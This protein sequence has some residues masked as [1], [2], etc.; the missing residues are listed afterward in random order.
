MLLSPHYLKSVRLTVKPA[1]ASDDAPRRSH[2]PHHHEHTS[3]L[4]GSDAAGNSKVTKKESEAL[5]NRMAEALRKA[6]LDGL[7]ESVNKKPPLS[8]ALAYLAQANIRKLTL[9]VG[10]AARMPPQCSAPGGGIA[11]PPHTK[12]I[13]DYRVRDPDNPEV[14]FDDTKK[15][16]KKME[17]YCGKDFQIEVRCLENAVQSMHSVSHNAVMY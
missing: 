6:R 2:D 8:A 5:V 17:L 11:Y 12:F 7:P 9:H 4:C 15:Y 16:G 10:S 13:F 14:F 1:A 3:G